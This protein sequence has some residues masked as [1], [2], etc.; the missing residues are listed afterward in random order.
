[1]QGVRGQRSAP[2]LL[3]DHQVAIGFDRRFVPPP[4]ESING[5]LEELEYYINQKND[6][7]DPLIRALLVH[8]QFEAIH[9][10]SDGNGRIGRVLLSLMIA[11]GHNHLM[12]WLYLSPYFEKHKEDYV[13]RLFRVSSEGDWE[14][15]VTFCL[16]GVIERARDAVQRCSDL[17]VL[18]RQFQEKIG[19]NCS[20]RI[21]QIVDDLFSILF[22]R[23]AYSRGGQPAGRRGGIGGGDLQGQGYFSHLDWTY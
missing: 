20:S 11:K 12:P 22:V 17:H 5:C 15:W 4:P 21:I 9:P 23:R 7:F 1:M 19:P 3:R 14:G 16:C 6:S 10:L 13:E 2:G 8:Y 18:K